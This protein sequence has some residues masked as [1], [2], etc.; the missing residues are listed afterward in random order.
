MIIPTGG[1][2][3]TPSVQMN[4]VNKAYSVNAV[5]QTRGRD[6]V[7][8]SRFSALVEQARAQAMAQPDIRADVVERAKARMQSGLPAC[9]DIASSL[10]NRAVEGQ[11]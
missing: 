2:D 11:V 8:I 5:E 7:A 6:V 9:S 1:V 3:K 4:K 10:I